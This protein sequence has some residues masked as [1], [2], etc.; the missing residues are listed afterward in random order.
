M[1]FHFQPVSSPFPSP[2]VT[3]RIA[4][5][6]IET[7]DVGTRSHILEI[8]IIISEVPSLL[9]LDIPEIWRQVQ[10]LGPN[11][12]QSISTASNGLATV[13]YRIPV[14]WQAQRDFGRTISQSTLDF[15]ANFSENFEK[16][17]AAA[18]SLDAQYSNLDQLQASILPVHK[19]LDTVRSALAGAKEIWINGLSFDPCIIKS[20][21]EDSSYIPK[22]WDFRAERDV[23]TIYQE[24]EVDPDVT[25]YPSHV[26][27]NDC[28]RNLAT[29]REMARLAATGQLRVRQVPLAKP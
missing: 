24:F 20:L 5:L 23:R 4:A 27:L 3:K 8:G 13:V 21:A 26:A 29:V 2:K 7:L 28:V 15:H 6:D 19:C 12:L 14:P 22:L 11:A 25:P 9:D 18:L 10:D 16:M 17:K 1:T